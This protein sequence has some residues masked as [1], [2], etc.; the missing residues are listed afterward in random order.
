MDIEGSE[1]LVLRKMI[2]DGTISRLKEIYI[3]FH[4]RFMPSESIETRQK[5]VEDIKNQGVIVHEWF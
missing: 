2:E 4:E 5:I 3:E 1:F